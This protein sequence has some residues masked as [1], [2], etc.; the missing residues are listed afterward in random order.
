MS[1]KNLFNEVL[2][3]N[4]SGS[5]ALLNQMKGKL[6][7]YLNSSASPDPKIVTKD[8][9]QAAKE[10]K[11]FAVI[12]HFS[13]HFLKHA[14]TNPSVNSL[15]KFLDQY[16]NQWSLDSLIQDF[17][18]EISLKDKTVLLHSNSGTIQKVLTQYEGSKS[19]LRIIQTYSSPSGEGLIQGGELSAKGFDLVLIHENNVWNRAE[20]IDF[21]LFGA[22]R[23][24]K[25]RFMNK[26]GTAQLCLVAHHIEQPVY[27]VADPRKMVNK[28]F[29]DFLDIKISDELPENAPPELMSKTLPGITVRNQNFEWIPFELVTKIYS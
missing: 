18:R 3:N 8:L 29:Y 27:V 6:R 20:T 12:I 10:L 22:D 21:F 11:D 19:G 14:Q 4:T 26:A 23:M 17:N 9:K 25:E 16:E 28:E 7:D 5:V 15:L 1:E 24:E 13:Y 2:K